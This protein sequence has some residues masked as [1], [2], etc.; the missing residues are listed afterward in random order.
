MIRLF[1]LHE[2]IHKKRKIK[3]KNISIK[4]KNNKR[5]NSWANFLAL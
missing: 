5:N 3:S 4:S 1:L 2:N